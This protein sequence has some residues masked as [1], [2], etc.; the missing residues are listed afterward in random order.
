VPAPK[1]PGR[2]GNPDTHARSAPTH[3]GRQPAR[4]KGNT[5]IRLVRK[6]A[7]VAPMNIIKEKKR[8]LIY[9]IT[10]EHVKGFPAVPE[11]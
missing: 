3:R 2:T 7:T 4:I 10:T 6:V 9:V 11:V 1:T 5:G 8:F